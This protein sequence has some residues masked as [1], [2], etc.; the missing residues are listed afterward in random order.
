M[1]EI[2]AVMMTYIQPFDIGQFLPE[3]EVYLFAPA[4]APAFRCCVQIIL[5]TYIPF[6]SPFF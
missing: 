3:N 2:T 1:Y 6:Y 5:L 4:P